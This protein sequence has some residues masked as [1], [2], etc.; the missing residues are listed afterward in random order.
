MRNLFICT[1]PYQYLMC[2]LI[3]EGYGYTNSELIVLN[4]FEGASSFVNKLQNLKVWSRVYFI[5]DAGTNE[6][7]SKLNPFQKIFFYQDWQKLLPSSLK[8]W[9]SY[10]S[11]YIAHEGVATEY[12]IMKKF[13]E[14][15]K[16]VIMY[17][18]GFGNYINVNQHQNI[19]KRMLK[20]V[21]HLFG[22]PG[23][24]LGRLKYVDKVLVQR[25]DIIINE[26]HNPIRKKVVR[27]PISLS[28]FLLLPNIRKEMNNIFPQLDE[29]LLQIE[30]INKIS[31]FLG[32][33]Y[34]A[35]LKNY[36]GYMDKI[37]EL[38]EDSSKDVDAIFIKQHPGDDKML[39]FGNRDKKIILIPKILPIELLYALFNEKLKLLKVFTLG[40]TA[41]INLHNLFLNQ[42]DIEVN[43]LS[44]K[45]LPVSQ[46]G[47]VQKFKEMAL[48]F[49][50]K[51]SVIPI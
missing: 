41:A 42:C 4:H 25:P 22:I 15:K 32:E 1:K 31:L 3:V 33:S 6:L 36:Q 2:R 35:K 37:I 11:L 7:S 46:S 40:S 30:G 13:Y 29:L 24:Y 9:D 12:G 45:T 8:N 20:E 26:K 39:E 18:E 28:E 51:H 17:E 19:F 34:N 50:V 21:S 27:L 16:P 49:G 10:E 43:I 48:K 47:N 14:F 5:D 44:D 38:V 23:S